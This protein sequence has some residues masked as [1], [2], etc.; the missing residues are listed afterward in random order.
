MI[1]LTG[2]LTRRNAKEAV[3]SVGAKL[4]FNLLFSFSR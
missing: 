2:L 3:G 1:G 4:L